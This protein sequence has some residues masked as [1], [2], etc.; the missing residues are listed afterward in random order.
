MLRP[1]ERSTSKKSTD[2]R[3]FG[4]GLRSRCLGC[5]DQNA[6]DPKTGGVSV[7]SSDDVAAA[8]RF[9]GVGGDRF[10]GS[11][12]QVALD[13]W[14]EFSA[15]GAKFDEAHVAELGLTH[16]EIAEAEGHAVGVNF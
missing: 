2:D 10:V 12:V 4:I 6:A 1:R 5:A 8:T 9:V 11:E 13:R 16:A 3:R 14:T 15:H 7:V